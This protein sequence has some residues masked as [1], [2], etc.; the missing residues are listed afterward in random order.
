MTVKELIQELKEIDK[1]Y[2]DHEVVIFNNASADKHFISYV[3]KEN[4]WE[5]DQTIYIKI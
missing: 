1:K 5:D 2:Q 4:E 3:E